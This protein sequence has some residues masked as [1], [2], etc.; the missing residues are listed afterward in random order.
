MAIKKGVDVLVYVN[1]GDEVT[2]VWTP[3]GGQRNATLTLETEDLD[4]TTKDSSGA[5]RE[6]L[7]TFI[8]WSVACDGLWVESDAGLQALRDNWRNRSLVTIRIKFADD[9]IE[10]GQ[11]IITSVDLDSPY[12]DAATYSAEFSGAS[13]LTPLTSMQ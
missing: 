7:A 9:D 3:I 1:T 10:E 6:R 8:S 5:M 2:P 11:A 13:E 4:V 12:D